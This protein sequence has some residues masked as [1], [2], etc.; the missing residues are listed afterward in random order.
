MVIG[1][2]V[3]FG[4]LAV[5]LLLFAVYKYWRYRRRRGFDQI[6]AQPEEHD[7]LDQV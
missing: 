7:D 2:S 1:L 5:A 6:G 4:L 3:G